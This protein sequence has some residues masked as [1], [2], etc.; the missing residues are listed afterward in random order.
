MHIVI[1]SLV[2]AR[3]RCLSVVSLL[4]ALLMMGCST[5]SDERTSEAETS[6][7]EAEPSGEAPLAY[8]F[9]FGPPSAD[10]VIDASA[11]RD[12]Y[13]LFK[14]SR[15]VG[16]RVADGWTG[17]HMWSAY[18][19]Q[20]G[21]GWHGG[22]GSPSNHHVRDTLLNP[23][24]HQRDDLPEYDM[25]FDGVL[26]Y[27]DRPCRFRVDVEPGT[28]DLIVYF[29]DLSLGENRHQAY[30]KVNGERVTEP[31]DTRGGEIRT[32]GARVQTIDGRLDIEF[33]TA[34][35]TAHQTSVS[36]FE[37]RRVDADS[38]HEFV[39]RIYP[40]SLGDTKSIA[41]LNLESYLENERAK[42]SAAREEL[43]AEG[44]PIRIFDWTEAEPGSTEINLSM[45][46]DPSRLLVFDRELD[47]SGMIELV[48][49]SGVD[50]IIV[51]SPEVARQY[52]D[53]GFHVSG[54]ASA[55]R[56]PAAGVKP[57]QI[58][59]TRD[60]SFTTLPG[61]FSILSD[62]VQSAI[63]KMHEKKLVPLKPYMD[64]IFVDEPR[65]MTFVSGKMGDYSAPSLEAFAEWS[66]AQGHP[67]WADAEEGPL[68][69]YSEAYYAF[70]RF[71][72]DAVPLYIDA[73]YEGTGL[74]G[75][76][77]EVGNGRIS[78]LW[79]AHHSF[80]PPALVDSGYD[81][82][83]WNY[84]AL[85]IAKISSEAIAAVQ[86]ADRRGAVYTSVGSTDPSNDLLLGLIALSA[87]VDVIGPREGHDFA[88]VMRIAA[89]ARGLGNRDHLCGVYLYWPK[90][91][92]FPD[93]VELSE[94]EAARWIEQA[95]SL[96]DGNLDFKVSYDA[97]VE[98]PSLLVYAPDKPVFTDREIEDLRAYLQSGGVLVTAFG[99]APVNVNG[100]FLLMWR[101]M[102]DAP[103]PGQIVELDAFPSPGKLREI[104]G[105]HGVAMN[106][107]LGDSHALLTYRFAGESDEALMLL[108]RDEEDA[109][110]V[111]LQ[112][113]AMDLIRGKRYPAGT[114]IE[115][116]S[117]NGLLL[118]LDPE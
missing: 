23:L 6:I 3:T 109:Q 14:S 32:V 2:T 80:F 73:I 13:A 79:L 110:H 112:S 40:E 93:L 10:A 43:L 44:Y 100:E 67:E 22:H 34:H 103:D 57:P 20:K 35:P 108:N 28:Y 104:G 114:V 19:P 62:E 96:F 53:A 71:R 16:A 54:A 37:L 97:Q 90:S 55:E 74:E 95:T 77:T 107:N 42:W 72:L 56:L 45:Y 106:P 39:G 59:V 18:D 58:L 11:V 115:V 99:T 26:F 83:S 12:N 89:F 31:L 88:N 41:R 61:F 38:A 24:Y 64:G 101:Q 50:S 118:A 98:Q 5:A 49:D 84:H 46:G 52:S 1:S 51:N 91:L 69:G 65:G 8:R 78:P 94:N 7:V 33:S 9:D 116:P 29:G 27:P 75:I 81:V 15:D 48:R 60:G 111:T 70:H 25:V 85:N 36:G 102:L 47:V 113:A 76:R 30:V 117:G 87:R 17:I 82:A 105:E 86:D 21:F 68:P 4:A 66:K 63:R 92:I